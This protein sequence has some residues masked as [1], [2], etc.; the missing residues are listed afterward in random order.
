[1]VMKKSG[2]GSQTKSLVEQVTK[3]PCSIELSVDAKGVYR[4]TI[5]LYCEVEE[6]VSAVKR[7]KVVDGNLR[8]EF[9]DAG[10]E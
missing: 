8:E 4:W 1:M 10:E 6:L 2:S 9:H 3:A 7:L 5:K